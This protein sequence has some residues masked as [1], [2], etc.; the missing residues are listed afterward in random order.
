MVKKV[1]TVDNLVDMLTKPLPITKF[2]HCLDL[3]GVQT[4]DP[5]FG[6]RPAGHY[7]S[8]SLRRYS[9]LV[10]GDI[11]PRWRLGL[12]SFR[13]ETRPDRG[14]ARIRPER[15][16]SIRSSVRDFVEFG[17]RSGPGWIGG[18]NLSKFF[19]FFSRMEA[20]PA[21][22]AQKLKGHGQTVLNF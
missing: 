9:Y 17:L 19:L 10:V 2:Q 7:P 21:N 8:G 6:V 1:H 16:S 20:A 12:C 4:S 14:S 18:P 5:P 15:S 3:V 13:S 22:R 11:C